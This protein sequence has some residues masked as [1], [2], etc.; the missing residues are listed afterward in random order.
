MTNIDVL[1]AGIE[2]MAQ[3]AA[4][5]Q[6]WARVCVVVDGDMMMAGDKQPL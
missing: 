5:D 2:L 4:N 1:L 3:L 6:V